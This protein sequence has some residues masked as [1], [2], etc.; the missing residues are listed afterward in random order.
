RAG[1]AAIEAQRELVGEQRNAAPHV[2]IAR[3][4]GPAGQQNQIA[5]AL[6]VLV[7]ADDLHILLFAVDEDA[8]RIAHDAGCRDDARAQLRAN[9]L[10]IRLFDEIGLGL[11]GGL[12]ACFK[13]AVDDIR[14]QAADLFENVV[15]AGLRNRDDQDD[16][17]I[18]DQH[19]EARKKRAKR[20]STEGLEAEPERLAKMHARLNRPLASAASRLECET[21]R[22]GSMWRQGIASAD[23]ERYRYCALL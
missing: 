3:V 13:I 18:P 5:D 12:A 10:H 23:R 19:A 2:D 22:P 7:R 21:D 9:R 11:A 14:S 16:G 15:L 17:S 8:V 20:T 1:R 4:E 6:I